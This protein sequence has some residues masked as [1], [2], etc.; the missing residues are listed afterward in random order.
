MKFDYKLLKGR[1]IQKY[2]SQQN[3]A[4]TIGISK[5]SLSMKMNNKRQFSTSDIY[6][7]CGLLDIKVDEIGAYFFNKKV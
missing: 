4:E 3:F 5:N 6:K 1:I 7:L 2:G